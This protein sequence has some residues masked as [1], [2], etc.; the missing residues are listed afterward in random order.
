MGTPSATEM[1]NLSAILA[2]N[3]LMFTPPGSPHERTAQA[4][5]SNAQ[6]ALQAEAVKKAA[7][8]Q[9]K[10]QKKNSLFS[11]IGTVA[12]FALG[13]P[14]GA[15][16]GGGLGSMAGGGDVAQAGA[17]VA[18]GAMSTKAG[19]G[20]N[21]LLGKSA[22]PTT[23]GNPVNSMTP[24]QGPL[25]PPPAGQQWVQGPNGW[26]LAPTPAGAYN[27]GMP[28]YAAGTT[29]V[30]ATGMAMVHQGEAIIPAD[31]NP[32][33]QP[34]GVPGSP[35]AGLGLTALLAAGK[36]AQGNKMAMATQDPALMMKNNPGLDPRRAGG[37]GETLKFMGS[38]PGA[39]N[40]MGAGSIAGQM[41][42]SGAMLTSQQ[43][44]ALTPQQKMML[45]M[46]GGMAPGFGA[47]F[48]KSLGPGMAM[49]SMIPMGGN[50]FKLFG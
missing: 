49:G 26:E 22:P 6:A 11:G 39:G 15:A 23:A 31:Q 14:A 30:P 12:G 27:F 29:S 32:A 2:Q 3:T 46:S 10:A 17:Q 37:M 40:G 25:Q 43:A 44:K 24:G 36:T 41:T 50:R 45:Q 16:I 33:K 35:L 47:N 5:L 38:H 8:E 34:P 4:Q 13:G 28:Q 42:D 48:M 18:M 21:G 20:F 19:S 1:M 7:K 9:K